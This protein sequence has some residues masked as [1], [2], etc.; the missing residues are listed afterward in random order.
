MSFTDCLSSNY[1]LGQRYRIIAPIDKGGMGA[2]YKAEDM[3]LGDR[4]VAVKEMSQ[5]GLNPQEVKEAADAFKQEAIILA[6]LQ[7]P[8]LPRIFAHFEENRR[9]YL[10][11]EYIEGKTLESRLEKAP[12][13]K[14][15]VK[16]VLPV[17]L[18]LCTVLDYLHTR[19]PPIIYRDLKPSNIMLTQDED[20]YLIDFGIARLFKPGQLKDTVTFGTEGYAAPEQY[21]KAQTTSAADIY[22]LGINLHQMLSGND[23]TLSPF[24]FAPLNLDASYI[25]LEQLIMRMVEM[26]KDKRPSSIREIKQVLQRSITQPQYLLSVG[27]VSGTL[28]YIYHGH[29]DAVWAVAWSPDGTHLVSGSRDDTVQVWEAATGCEVFTYKGHKDDVNAVA[30]SPDGRYIASGS[31]DDTVRVR[32]ALTGR[33]IC[34][35]DG[36]SDCVNALTWS[37]DSARIASASDDETV[38]IWQVQTGDTLRSFDGHENDDPFEENRV[39]A[40]AWSPDGRYIASASDEADVQ[41]WEAVTGDE[42]FSY[43]R[44]D[45]DV[46]VVAWSPNGRYIAS[47]SSD[48]TVRV[49]DVATQRGVARYRGHA[50][51]V[52]AL[53]WSPDSMYIASAS[54][55]RTARIWEAT[56]KREVFVYRGHSDR[57]N[58]VAWSPDGKLIASGSDDYTVQV[59]LAGVQTFAA[60]LKQTSQSGLQQAVL[61]LRNIPAP[62]PAAPPKVQAPA[63]VPP[64]PTPPKVTSFPTPPVAPPPSANVH[65]VAP[66]TQGHQSATGMEWRIRKYQAVATV[67]GTILL[68]F[69][70]L[71]LALAM[72]SINPSSVFSTILVVGTALGLVEIT[73]LF[74]GAIFGPWAGLITGGVGTFIGLYFISIALPDS[75][76]YQ[77]FSY[78]WPPLIGITIAGF[79]AGLAWLKTQGKYNTPSAI[80]TAEGFSALGMIGFAFSFYIISGDNPAAWLA[81]IPGLVFL[82]ILLVIYNAV[83]KRRG[84]TLHL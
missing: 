74:F 24:H 62:S 25:D 23:P 28:I 17:G 27:A 56:T 79:L 32:D 64:I 57:V 78:Y 45:D 12:N 11:M 6:G 46:N 72:R 61:P 1:L 35:Y 40:V 44:H 33:K 8:N 26:D 77:Q 52:R 5:S 3:Q 15:S 7:H 82:P 34:R 60:A 63:I 49:R 4:F 58:T 36:H 65:A 20:L 2:V 18:Q 54:D 51:C 76:V 38:H 19:Q 41:V 71:L 13:G 83:V 81:S 47:G 16:D 9:W 84:H 66:Q 80:T 43:E 48:F 39:L 55:D 70:V 29:S 50:D 42:L 69:L 30:W 37:P 75:L 22:S 31:D 10:V 73:P 59:W 53:S 14:L 67:W 21:G 68:S